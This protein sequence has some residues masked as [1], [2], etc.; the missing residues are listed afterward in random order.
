MLSE[1]S[2]QYR[3]QMADRGDIASLRILEAD[4]VERF[5]EARCE[6]GGSAKLQDILREYRQWG[7][8][9]YLTAY[10]LRKYLAG[11][12]LTLFY[13][14]DPVGSLEAWLEKLPRTGRIR[15]GKL[16]KAY[17]LSGGKLSN[18]AFGDTMKQ[19]GFRDDVSRKYYLELSL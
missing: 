18:R 14:D 10:R 2:R 12:T 13:A 4:D 9:V 6:E 16:L 11:R 1:T 15:K 8:G 7:Q 3:R 19:L 5:I 17:R